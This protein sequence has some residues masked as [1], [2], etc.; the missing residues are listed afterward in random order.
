MK[1]SD[2]NIFSEFNDFDD[3]I[4]EKIAEKYS[5]LSENEVRRI[6]SKTMQKIGSQN[7]S[8]TEDSVKGTE[9]IRKSNWYVYGSLV[10]GILVCI[11][12]LPFMVLSIKK[13]PEETNE[14]I[15]TSMASSSYEST[16]MTVSANESTVVTSITASEISAIETTEIII[17]TTAP[18]T[19]EYA[20]DT[21]LSS[22]EDVQTTGEISEITETSVIP[23]ITETTTVTDVYN[24]PVQDYSVADT[25]GMWMQTE[26]ISDF[27]Y[28]YMDGNGGYTLYNFNGAKLYISDGYIMQNGDESMCYD[29]YEMSGR[30]YGSLRFENDTIIS[31][32]N[33]S[34][35]R[36]TRIFI[37][38]YDDYE[39]VYTE[40]YGTNLYI[41]KIDEN[42]YSVDISIYRVAGI[43]GFGY[44]DENDVFK[45]EYCFSDKKSGEILFNDDSAELTFN[46]S[47]LY[48]PAGSVIN[49][50][51][52]T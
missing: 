7:Y 31:F 23:E 8:S 27:F 34:T 28:I 4:A 40:E 14:I 48:I 45:F 44:F 10:A 9:R 6:Y 20:F 11:G 24:E 49:F 1:K 19:E 47:S 3:D 18:I 12:I 26:G 17:E 51:K 46:E 50:H 29:M 42:K 33:D 52:Q 38:S 21:D 13:I 36:Y 39:G 15:V 2:D 41:K 37:D 35:S 30:Y 22:M 5:D 32:E 25:K 43:E 16:I